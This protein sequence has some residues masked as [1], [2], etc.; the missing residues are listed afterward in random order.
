M[1]EMPKSE[2]GR[3][4]KLGSKKTQLKTLSDQGI[5]K[6]LTDPRW[7]PVLGNYRNGLG[8]PDKTLLAKSMHWGGPPHTTA[9]S[10][11]Q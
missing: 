10:S 3:P 4:E 1:T 5:D 8:A 9:A 7:D 2:G 11:S 6:H